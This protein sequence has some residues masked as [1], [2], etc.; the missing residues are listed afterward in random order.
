[1]RVQSDSDWAGDTK[2]RKSTSGGTIRLGAHLVKSWSKDQGSIATS[3]AE[4]ELYAATKAA[5]EALG[6][7]I[8][9]KDFGIDIEINMEIDAKA[10]IGIVSRQGLGRLKHVEVHDLWIQEAIKR[11]RL[12]IQKIPRA[13]NTADLLASP[14][15]SEDIKKFMEE[16]CF[17]FV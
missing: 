2:T 8:A 5:S 3:S 6:L 11:G 13:I 15:K 1:M 16:L 9:L 14:S 10:T 7:Q 12:K 17:R 4:A